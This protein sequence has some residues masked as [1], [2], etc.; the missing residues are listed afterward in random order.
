LVSGLGLKPQLRIGD[1]CGL[2][3][4]SRADS[5]FSRKSPRSNTNVRDYITV[6]QSLVFAGMIHG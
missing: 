6:R 1:K 5:V 3:R 4:V 2:Q